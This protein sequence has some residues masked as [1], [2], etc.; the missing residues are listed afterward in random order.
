MD[1]KE[2]TQSK[3]LF[4]FVLGIVFVIIAVCRFTNTPLSIR[5]DTKEPVVCV[6][7][8]PAV[9]V[10]KPEKVECPPLEHEPNL[11]EPI[12]PIPV[13]TLEAPRVEAICVSDRGKSSVFIQGNSA[14]EGDVVDGFKIVKI[15]PNNVEFEKDGKTI[16]AVFPRP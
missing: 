13:V 10:K 11:P 2:K 5:A 7:N 16:T 14:Y 6:L 15:Y 3:L 8:T 1:I 9:S 4:L 12:L